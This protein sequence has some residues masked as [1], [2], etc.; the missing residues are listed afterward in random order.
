MTDERTLELRYLFNTGEN[1]SREDWQAVNVRKELL[2]RLKELPDAKH[3]S[4]SGLVNRAVDEWLSNRDNLIN[5]SQLQE[6]VPQWTGDER[7]A[8]FLLIAQ[9][10]AA[11]LFESRSQD[12]DGELAL[13][14]W[15]QVTRG[16]VPSPPELIKLA[17]ALDVDVCDLK[18]RINKLRELMSNGT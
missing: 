13:N 6:S 3:L 5:V 16:E 8:A 12:K 11:D 18:R 7:M 1:V 4:Q 15:Q 17:A 9:Y 2:N 14:C 10:V